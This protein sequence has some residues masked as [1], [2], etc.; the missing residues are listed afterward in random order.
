MVDVK[1]LRIGN[2]PATDNITLHSIEFEQLVA[3]VATNEGLLVSFYLT[4]KEPKPLLSIWTTDTNDRPRIEIIS[5]SKLT[6]RSIPTMMIDLEQTFTHP[7][8]F[9]YLSR[10]YIQLTNWSA[11]KQI[12]LELTKQTSVRNSFLLFLIVKSSIIDVVL[13]SVQLF[14]RNDEF[15][16]ISE[17][18]SQLGGETT[19]SSCLMLSIGKG[20]INSMIFI[21]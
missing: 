21:L 10:D 1:E 12:N 11:G 13:P 18:F 8:L 9:T 19:S 15:S 14:V 20:T 5:Q 4:S 16:F 7:L 2:R 6:N 3:Y 17:I